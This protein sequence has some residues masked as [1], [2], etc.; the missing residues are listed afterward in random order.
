[1][2]PIPHLVLQGTAL[3]SDDNATVLLL[4]R[5]SPNGQ[6]LLYFKMAGSNRVGDDGSGD[7]TPVATPTIPL[8]T[9]WYV[10]QADGTNPVALPQGVVDAVWQ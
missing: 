10:A 9:R 2:A 8:T 7:P 4:P 6:F 3:D 5:P 1:M